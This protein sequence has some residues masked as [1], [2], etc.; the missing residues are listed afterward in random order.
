MSQYALTEIF[1]SLQGEGARIGSGNVFVRFAGCNRLCRKDPDGFDCDTKFD[2]RLSLSGFELVDAMTAAL[3]TFPGPDRPEV[4]RWAVLTGGEPTLQVDAYLVSLLK[5]AGWKLAIET[6]GA[7]A[8][9]AGI[10]WITVSPKGRSVAIVQ[11]AANEVKYTLAPGMTI[12]KDPPVR[13]AYRWIVPAAE[14]KKVPR[15]NVEWC[16]DQVKRHP[17]WRLSPQMHKIWGL[18]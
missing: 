18:R 8:V 9:A 7:N 12:P 1:W 4:D 6:N 17:K 3:P 16:V 2:P 10:D 15:K 11:R 14:G 13:A 5:Q